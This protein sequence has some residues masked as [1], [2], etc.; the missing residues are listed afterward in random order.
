MNLGFLFKMFDLLGPEIKFYSQSSSKLKSNLGSV[1]TIIIFLFSILCFIGL[2]MDMIFK[3]NPSLFEYR[4][5]NLTS[6]IELAKMPFSIGIMR[7]GGGIINEIRRKVKVYFKYSITNS[8]NLNQPTEYKIFDLVPCTEVNLFKSNEN[9]IKSKLIGDIDRFYCLP[10][11]FKESLVGQFGNPF[12][13]IGQIYVDYC[14]NSTELSY[15]LPLEIIKADLYLFFAQYVFLDY[16]SDLIDYEN[17]LKAYWRSNLIQLSSSSFRTDEYTFRVMNVLTDEGLIMDS[18]RLLSSFQFDSKSGITSNANNQNILVIRND[19]SNINLFTGRKYM[20]IQLVIANTGGFIKFL[21]MLASFLLSYLNR[22]FY[23]ETIYMNSL[24]F[25]NKLCIDEPSTSLYQNSKIQMVQLPVN[26][27]FLEFN[28]DFVGKNKSQKSFNKETEIIKKTE[29]NENLTQEKTK[30]FNFRKIIYKKINVCSP[31][32][33]NNRSMSSIKKLD[34]CFKSEMDIFNLFLL[35]QNYKLI[36]NIIFDENS[37]RSLDYIFHIN[38]VNLVKGNENIFR[39]TE[40]KNMDT[41]SNNESLLE[42]IKH[43]ENTHKSID[44]NRSLYQEFLKISAI[45]KK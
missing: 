32:C 3:R 28:S 2:G 10:N 29:K 39:K 27:N 40:L 21:T 6:E 26:N 35:F 8:S 42:N 9:S 17:P 11:N 14:R 4:N 41:I 43:L 7:P 31:L 12:F 16:Y 19:I 36:E 18:S 45:S 1:L 13:Q 25:F 44:I 37:K 22:Y 5:F 33:F 20:K 24:S 30:N 34:N 15:C 38:L 23:I